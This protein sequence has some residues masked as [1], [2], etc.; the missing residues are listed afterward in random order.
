[1]LPLLAALVFSQKWHGSGQFWG[2]RVVTSAWDFADLDSESVWA[3]NGFSI[4]RDPWVQCRVIVGSRWIL[5]MSVYVTPGSRRIRRI[6]NRSP[7]YSGIANPGARVRVLSDNAIL[8]NPTVRFGPNS[9]N[10]VPAL[11]E[12]VRD[13]QIGHR[14]PWTPRVPSRPIWQFIA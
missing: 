14:T 4:S 7:G 11:W 10:M 2:P 8:A 12:T 3:P 13:D 6:V 9:Q 5:D 1:M